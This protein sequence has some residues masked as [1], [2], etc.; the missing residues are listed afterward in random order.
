MLVLLLIQRAAWQEMVDATIAVLLANAFAFGLLGVVVVAG[1]VLNQI[2]RPAGKL[3]SQER[4]SG[5]YWR[6]LHQLMH[7]MHEIAHLGGM[8]LTSARYEDHVTLQVTGG[9]VVLAMADLP[10]EVWH[11]QSR[12]TEPTYGVVQRLAWREGLVTTLVC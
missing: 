6:L 4:G 11:K 10:A 1:Q 5:V 2:Q 3:L 12:V 7:L 9:L 8:L